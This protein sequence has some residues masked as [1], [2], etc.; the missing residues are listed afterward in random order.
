M[1]VVNTERLNELS[2]ELDNLYSLYAGKKVKTR[3][4]DLYN[5]PNWHKRVIKIDIFRGVSLI[6]VCIKW[7]NR[8]Q[9]FLLHERK[10]Y[11]RTD[12]QS[13]DIICKWGSFVGRSN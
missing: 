8:K 6:T 7:D 2:Q 5:V 11:E 4:R 13:E 12:V 3:C 1:S 10:P 9:F